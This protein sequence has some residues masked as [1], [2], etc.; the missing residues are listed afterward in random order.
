[1]FRCEYLSHSIH[2]TWGFDQQEVFEPISPYNGA[3]QYVSSH[4]AKS[5]KER[6]SHASKQRTKIGIGSS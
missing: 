5:A 1:M 6:R 4:G 2:D 3:N